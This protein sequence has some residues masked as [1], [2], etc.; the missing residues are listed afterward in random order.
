M[1]MVA[2]QIW[3]WVDGDYGRL[4][5]KYI[6]TLTGELTIELVPRSID[7]AD[8]IVSVTVE[9]ERESLQPK[10]IMVL[11]AEGDSTLIRFA[12]YRLN[13]PVTDTLFSTCYP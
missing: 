13:E 11:E 5:N 2:E 4:Q 8:V 1:N 9:L 6:I 12:N 3:T 7:F 10:T